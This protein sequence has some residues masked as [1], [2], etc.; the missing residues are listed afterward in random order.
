M[1][2][3]HGLA[4]RELSPTLGWAIN[5]KSEAAPG[6]ELSAACCKGGSVAPSGCG[7]GAARIIASRSLTRPSRRSDFGAGAS[8]GSSSA[9]TSSGHR[10]RWLTA[11]RTSV[12][13]AAPA[14][15]A[16]KAGMAMSLPRATRRQHG[17]IKSGYSQKIAASR[18]LRF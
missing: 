1:D 12:P 18:T 13:I 17:E 8:Y 3:G 10:A 2:E 14:K 4:S 6:V 15:M 7:R 9:A 11:T 16:L 5:D